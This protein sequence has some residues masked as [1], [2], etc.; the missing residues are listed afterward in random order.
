MPAMPSI[1]QRDS[2]FVS[3]NGSNNAIPSVRTVDSLTTTGSVSS[4]KDE[5]GRT[6][7]SP[8]ATGA[9]GFVFTQPSAFPSR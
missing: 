3:E 8:V 6:S 7:I 4:G 9:A 2:S 1:A 5:S